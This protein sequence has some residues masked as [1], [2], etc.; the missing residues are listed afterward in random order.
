MF[1]LPAV[2]MPQLTSRPAQVCRDLNTMGKAFLTDGFEL[3]D[4]KDIFKRITGSELAVE[5]LKV[6]QPVEEDE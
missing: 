4:V 2:T 1:T 5:N 3:D 6:Q